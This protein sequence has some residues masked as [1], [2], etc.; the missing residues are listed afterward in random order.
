MKQED[1]RIGA[2]YKLRG[3]HI[4]RFHG[5]QTHTYQIGRQTKVAS[6]NAFC[7]VRKPFPNEEISGEYL[8]TE[9]VLREITKNDLSELEGRLANCSVRNLPEEV[10]DMDFLIAEL[11]GT[12]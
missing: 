10:A 9:D 12:P 3:G 11:K 6:G 4:L 1:L 8:P 5:I 7:C 2:I